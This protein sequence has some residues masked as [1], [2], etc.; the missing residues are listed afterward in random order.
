MNGLQRTRSRKERSAAALK[1]QGS[2]TRDF[3][4]PHE[5][6]AKVTIVLGQTGTGKEPRQKLESNRQLLSARQ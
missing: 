5:N 6:R 1:V 2:G 3:L 4:R